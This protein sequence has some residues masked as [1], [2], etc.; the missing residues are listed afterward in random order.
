LRPY[1][2]ISLGDM[3]FETRETANN[4]DEHYLINSEDSEFWI[5]VKEGDVVRLVKSTYTP[6]A[7]VAI[8]TKENF[9]D[10]LVEGMEQALDHAKCSH[11]VVVVE[12]ECSEE[13]ESATRWCGICYQQLDVD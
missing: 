3:G 12:V 11:D 7:E 8:L 5:K 9:G 6:P 13:V 10:K 2:C 4:I 1:W